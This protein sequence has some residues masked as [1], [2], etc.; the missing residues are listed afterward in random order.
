[1]RR[2]FLPLA[3]LILAASLEPAAAAMVGDASVPFRAERTVTVGT[4]TY[5]GLL[6]HTP[7]HQRHEQDLM[8]MREVFLL[9][10]A[11][12]QGELVLPG[13]KTYVAF[14]F[15]PL[16]ADLAAPDL[17]R[18]PVAQETISGIRTTKYR[19][20]HRA[21]DGS[22]AQGYLLVSRAGMLMKLDLAVTHAHGG[23]PLAIAMG[24]T[25]VE[26]GPQDPRLFA[27]PEGFVKLPTDALAPLLGAKPAG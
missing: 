2:V 15:P 9:D 3:A 26:I 24:L 19:I 27:P 12:S 18:S 23:K 13:L 5:T 22:R 7:G 25:H 8:G 14:P 11:T 20:D 16:M 21:A 17:L 10:T 4:H 1:M 6:F